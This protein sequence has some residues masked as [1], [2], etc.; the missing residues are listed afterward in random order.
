MRHISPQIEL[1]FTEA[2]K[3]NYWKALTLN[4]ILDSAIL[5]YSIKLVFKALNEGAVATELAEKVPLSS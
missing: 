5:G 1:V 4:G 2:L 3:G